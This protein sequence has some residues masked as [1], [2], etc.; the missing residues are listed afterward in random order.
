M[1]F[2]PPV[3]GNLCHRHHIHWLC[4][5]DRVQPSFVAELLR[6]DAGKVLNARKLAMV[7]PDTASLSKVRCGHSP[8]PSR[9]RVQHT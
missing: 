6:D 1:G 2:D 7:Q 5:G 3:S 8:G 9:C 4:A